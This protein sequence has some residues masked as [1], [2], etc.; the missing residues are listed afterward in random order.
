MLNRVEIGKRLS[1][2][3]FSASFITLLT[4]ISGIYFID[5]VGHT[6]VYVGEAAAPLVDAVMESK[7]LATE[8]HLKFEEIMGGDNAESIDS[9]NL[10]MDKSSWFLEAIAHGGES[11][12]GKFIAVENPATLA[13]VD[14]SRQ[15]LQAVRTMLAKRYATLG[16]NIGED[17]FHKLDAQFDADFEAFIDEVDQLETA[18]QI[19]VKDSLKKLHDTTEES[20]LILSALIGAALISALLLG[21]LTTQSITQPLSQC[22]LIAKQI[23]NG[24]L[25]AKVAPLGEDEIAQLLLALDSMRR[26]LLDIISGIA[27]NVTMLNRAAE[28]LASASSQSERASVVEA[29]TSEM[30]ANSVEKLSQAIDQIGRQAKTVYEVAEHSGNLSL[31]SGTIIQ[32][33]ASKITDVAAAVK[34]TAVTIQE[35]EDFSGQISGIVSIIG[36][37]ADQTNL[38]ALNAAIEAARA[39][40]QGRGFA[41]VA[42]EVRA[43][44]KRTASST[45]EII[46]MV[47]KIQVNTKHA[48]EEVESGVRKVNDGVALAGKAATSITDIRDSSHHVSTAIGEIT[49]ILA[50]QANATREMAKRIKMIADSAADNCSTAAGASRSAQELARLAQNL[51]RVVSGFKIV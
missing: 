1:A 17:Q 36:S 13:R 28:S 14:A 37:I 39:G 44:A 6:G 15:K 51:E 42:D 47:G 7:L 10:L 4:G 50:D 3:F 31:T 34:S 9:V 33:T 18:I 40:E 12:E 29:E 24:D 20:K 25:T 49:G 35:L 26:R 5:V 19:D 46:D 8:A 11:E 38:L 27:D 45:H 21:R 41:V 30:M 23:Q 48:A 16:Q 2:A 43:L 22:L 32:E